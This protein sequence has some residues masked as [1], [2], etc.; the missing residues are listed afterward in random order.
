VS[1]DETTDTTD[2]TLTPSGSVGQIVT[3]TAGA[4]GTA[5]ILKC[6]I[7]GGVDPA[8]G[9]VSAAMTTTGKWFV[10]AAN[11]LEVICVDEQMESNSTFGWTE[12]INAAIRQAAGGV[13]SG[14]VTEVT[15][16]AP[17]TVTSPTTTPALAITA[18]SGGAAGSMSSAH[19][20]KLNNFSVSGT[21]PIQV[22]TGTTTPVVSIDA[23]SGGA[24]GSMSSAHYTKLNNFSVSGTAPI[25][26]ATGTTTPVVSIDAAT[27]SA[28]GSQSAAH[29]AKI[30]SGVI[31][32]GWADCRT[33][34]ALAANVYSAT[35]NGSLTASSN[36][37]MAAVDGVTP[38]AGIRILV[39]HEATTANRGPY[40]VTS[41]GSG[42]TPYVLT[43]VA[44]FVHGA[45]IVGD[46]VFHIHSGTVNGNKFCRSVGT[47]TI[48]GTDSWSLTDLAVAPASV[49]TALASAATDIAIN[50]HKITGMSDGTADTDG[51]NYGQVLDEARLLRVGIDNTDSPYSASWG[52]Y[53]DVDSS[54]GAVTITLPTLASGIDGTGRG[55]AI[56][57]FLSTAGNT[58]TIDG[59]GS[60]TVNGAANQTMSVQ[61]S[62]RVLFPGK[63]VTNN[64]HMSGAA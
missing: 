14:T 1:T 22:A 39:G 29:F 62:T 28:A 54:G 27:A 40:V 53:I 51:A 35:G 7:N 20:T 60:E 56:T 36:G 21:T 19:Y 5:G 6:T 57:V 47:T 44:P 50:T 31:E 64:I 43:R 61:Y 13:G 55:R 15:V 58:V 23:A 10:P 34:A 41:A 12:P 24:A 37:A 38:T 4:A 17:L 45:T 46:E 8:T 32:G 3:F 48:V 11:M 52:E 49:V 59:N 18:A 16:T 25:Q 26:V 42:G 30:S 33:T 63:P 2:Y 9:E